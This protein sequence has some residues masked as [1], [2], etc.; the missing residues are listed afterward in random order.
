MALVRVVVP[1]FNRAFA[2]DAALRSIIA[3]T[4]ADF[5]VLVADDGSSDG[6]PEIVSALAGTDSRIQLLRLSHGGVSRTRNSAISLPG[7]HRYVAFLDSDDIWGPS[8]LQRAL[9]A[10]ENFSDAAIYCSMVDVDDVAQIWAPER[11]QD[12]QRRVA[13]PAAIAERKLDGDFYLVTAPRAV[14]AFL[15]DEFTLKPSSMVLRRDAVGRTMWFRED[16]PVMED[17][18]FS[19]YLVS[20]GNNLVFDTQCHVRLRR[21]GDN[22]S[23]AA[24]ALSERAVSG[25][26]SVVEYQ[27]SKLAVCRSPQER[28]LVR[29]KVADSLY[30]LAQNFAQRLELRSARS[31]YLRSLGWRFSYRA[32]KGAALSVLPA[33]A[34]R[35]LRS[36]LRGA[37]TAQ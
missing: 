23:G 24:N 32:I 3:Q 30:L 13:R 6:T 16:L 7:S 2:I 15:A 21:F 17:A 19:L 36:W 4:F 18:E 20:R 25:L 14:T 22:L 9:D 34:Y 28:V 35:G 5:E 31:T 11:L 27:K 10:L 29:R 26:Q 8:H 1:V 12:Q 37:G 33:A